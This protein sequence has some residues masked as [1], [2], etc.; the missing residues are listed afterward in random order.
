MANIENKYTELLEK[1]KKYNTIPVESIEVIDKQVQSKLISFEKGRSLLGQLINNPDMNLS[2]FSQSTED[3]WAS[4]AA[5]IIES[6]ERIKSNTKHQLRAAMWLIPVY[7]VII[8]LCSGLGLYSNDVS[9][10]ILA[11]LIASLFAVLAHSFFLLRTHQ[12]SSIAIERL[13][14][15]RLAILFLKLADSAEE[16]KMDAK[17]LLE[18]GTKMFMNHHAPIS[19]PLTSEDGKIISE[20]SKKY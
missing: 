9:T 10:T 20:V 8:L 7:I 19:I 4:L 1:A 2:I 13:A 18:A 17:M 5:I 15:K 12:Q 14:E 6:E 16:G 3:Q 11:I